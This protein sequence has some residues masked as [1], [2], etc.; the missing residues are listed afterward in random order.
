M[1]LGRWTGPTKSLLFRGWGVSYGGSQ[2]LGWRAE[3]EIATGVTVQRDAIRVDI[4]LGT[5]QRR[6]KIGR[7]R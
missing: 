1:L 3:E 6:F 2:Y 5:D 4:R 7:H